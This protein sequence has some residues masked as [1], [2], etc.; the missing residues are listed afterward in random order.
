MTARRKLSDAVASREELSFVFGSPT[1]QKEIALDSENTQE[2]SV[3]RKDILC[4]FTFVPDGKPV[5][6][7]YDTEDLTQWAMHDIKPNGIRSPIWVRPHPTKP[8]KYE[9]VAGLRR[10][11]AAEIANLSTVPVKVF[12]WDN[13]T[14]FQASIAENANRRDFSALEELDNT[15]RLLEI[16][17]AW[18]SSEV[19]SLLYRMNNAAKGTTNQNVLVSPEAE[20]VKRTFESFGKITWQSFVSSRLPLLKKP[21]DVLEAIR[22]GAI[23]YTKGILIASVKDEKARKNLLQA[24]KKDFLSVAEIKRQIASLNQGGAASKQAELYPEDLKQRLAQAMKLANKRSDL[25]D[26][27][28]KLQKLDRLITQLETLIG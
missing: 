19:V 26:D 15:L 21:E 4:T 3:P 13:D 5:R 17:L 2:Q 28:Q 12:R 7:Y 9:L 23:H 25:W 27:D 24:V 10:Y 20:M 18:E 8:A 1:V 14:A 22:G 16:Q 11:K 6:H